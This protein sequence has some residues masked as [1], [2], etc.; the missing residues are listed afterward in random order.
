MPPLR[1]FDIDGNEITKDEYLNL[2]VNQNYRQIAKTKVH[3]KYHVS[4]HWVGINLATRGKAL[5]FETVVQ[6]IADP[7]KMVS[8]AKYP[9]KGAALTGHRWVIRQMRAGKLHN[10]PK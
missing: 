3:S 8:I 6:L 1:Y 7:E 10:L 4:T 9:T 2:F 5:Y